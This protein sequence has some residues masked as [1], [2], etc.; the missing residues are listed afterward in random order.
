MQ[1]ASN[2]IFIAPFYVAYAT[3][4]V[5]KPFDYFD[6][7][8]PCV[9]GCWISKKIQLLNKFSCWYLHFR[10]LKMV[11]D[12][13]CSKYLKSHCDIKSCKQIQNVRSD[14][15]IEQIEKETHSCKTSKSEIVSCQWAVA[16]CFYVGRE[17]HGMCLVV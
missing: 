9:D 1:F 3:P 10:G 15:R 13:S 14:H 5:K 17:S 2:F 16:V 11:W 12:L 4:P 7:I 6:L 8:A